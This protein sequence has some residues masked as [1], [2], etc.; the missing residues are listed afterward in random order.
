M[1][2]MSLINAKQEIVQSM[3]N[4]LKNEDANAYEQAMIQLSESIKDEVLEEAKGLAGA[5]DSEIL[6]ARGVRQLTSKERAY[7]VE[8]GKAMTSENPR[9]A[10]SNI[11]AVM[12]ETEIDAIFDGLKESHALLAELDVQNTKGAIKYIYNTDARQLA[13]WGKL[14]DEIKKEI[15]ASFTEVDM[16]L[17]KLT[18][19]IP[20]SQAMVDLGPEWLE[21]FIRQVLTEALACGLENAVVNNLNDNE[22]CLGMVVDF[23]K[24]ATV[25]SSTGVTTYKKQTATKVTDFKPKTY[26]PIVAKLAKTEGGKDRNVHDLILVCNPTDYYNKIMPATVREYAGA[27]VHDAFPIA[28]KVVPCS[29]VTE[30]EAILGMSGQY[31]LGIGMG[32]TDGV[33]EYSDDAQ[34]IEDNRVFKTKLYANGK[35]KD[36]N[37]FIL[38]DVSAVE[39]Y[40]P[41][42]KTTT[43]AA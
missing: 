28:T 8:L 2:K 36:A 38:L 20:V 33:I 32:S 14:T 15:S 5:K 39:A 7:F 3:T 19:F 30:G 18:A 13:V 12:P 9:Q 43:A 42:V 40:I 41:E 35:P 23:T 6:S 25:S 24:S 11:D 27:Y 26:G 1:T 17:L 31:F 4:A 16:T 37:S 21:N 22:G 10:L 34:F 29:A